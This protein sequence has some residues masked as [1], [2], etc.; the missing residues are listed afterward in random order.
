MGAI[1]PSGV[2]RKKTQYAPRKLF[3]ANR[4]SGQGLGPGERGPMGYL[5]SRTISRPSLKRLLR[6]WQDVLLFRGASGLFRYAEWRMV[7]SE[8]IDSCFRMAIGKRR[9]SKKAQSKAGGFAIAFGM[10]A[11]GGNPIFTA[12]KPCW[13]RRNSLMG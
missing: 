8:L 5:S 4:E 11:V 10:F 13:R 2:V 6:I 3:L 7:G 9:I 1:A 12:T